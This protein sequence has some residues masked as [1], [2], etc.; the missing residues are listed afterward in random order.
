MAEPDDFEASLDEALHQGATTAMVH[1]ARAVWARVASLAPGAPAPRTRYLPA[2]VHR[3]NSTCPFAAG[4]MPYPAQ[5][6][7][8]W[9]VPGS[10][11]NVDVT[12]DGRIESYTGPADAKGRLMAP[13]SLGKDL[14]GVAIVADALRDAA[15]GAPPHES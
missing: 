3:S 4:D 13:C 8:R 2:G 14:D 12:E 11:V 10:V 6:T 5:I 7:L 9:T 1:A 15:P